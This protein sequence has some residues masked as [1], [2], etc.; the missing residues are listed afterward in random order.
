MDSANSLFYKKV[1][2]NIS[3]GFTYS[4]LLSTTSQ[5]LAVPLS[6]QNGKRFACFP[7]RQHTRINFP[8]DKVCSFYPFSSFQRGKRAAFFPL[9][10]FRILALCKKLAAFGYSE[11]LWRFQV[12]PDPKIAPGLY[13]V[14]RPGMFFWG[15]PVTRNV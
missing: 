10:S 15:E 12:I 5:R 13:K 6:L 11:V 4:I 9:I 7:L 3:H 2:S 8:S 1:K 14:V